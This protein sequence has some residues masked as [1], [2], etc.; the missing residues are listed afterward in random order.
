M[1]SIAIVSVMILL[2]GCTTPGSQVVREPGLPGVYVVNG[3]DPVGNEYSGTVSIEETGVGSVRMEWVITGAI[4]EG[5]GVVDGDRLAV[6]WES[7]Q[8]PRGTS[9][10]TATYTIEPDGTLRGVRTIDGVRGEGTEEIF[11]SG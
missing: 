9:S 10:G 2:A 4:L 5:E 8:T 6:D 7:V 1:R 3:F 11:P